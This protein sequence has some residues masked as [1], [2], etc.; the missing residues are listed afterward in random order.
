MAEGT[1]G[2][3]AVII[4]AKIGKLNA[5]LNQAKQKISGFSKASS[6]KMKNFSDSFSRAG[7]GITAFG[8]ITTLVMKKSIDMFAKFQKGLADVST[9]LDQTTLKFMKQYTKGVKDLS[10]EFGEATDSL[11]KGLYDILS[12]S[13]DASKAM[14]VLTVATKAAKA[15]VTTTAVAVDAITTILNSYGMEAEEAMKVSDILFATVKRGKITFEEL[16]QGIGQV[17]SMGAQAG[18]SLEA[19]TAT[20]ATMTRMG[21]KSAEAMT[22]MRGILRGFL[23]PVDDAKIAFDRYMKSIGETN[24]HLDLNTLESEGLI[25][26]LNKLSGANA[27]LLAKMFPNIRGLK[28]ILAAMADLEGVT[29]DLALTTNSAGL[30]MIAFEK[31]TATLDF[32][33]ERLKKG[34]SILMINAITPLTQG[35]TKIATLLADVISKVSEW[36]EKH[37]V[38]TKWIV[39]INIVLGV[40]AVVVGGL[41][42]AL[43][44]LIILIETMT[45]AV[46]ALFWTLV[47]SP[48]VAVTLGLGLLTKAVLNHKEARVKEQNAIADATLALNS[49]LERMIA[50]RKEIEELWDNGERTAEQSRVY[51]LILQAI[52]FYKQELIKTNKELM[53]SGLKN[54]R[55][56][57]EEEEKAAE[58]TRKLETD[59]TDYK[60]SLLDK[61]FQA[62]LDKNVDIEVAIK[63]HQA[64]IKEIM[65][66]SFEE[67][68]ELAEQY[69]Q[70][71]ID[72][73]MS[74]T[75]FTLEEQD[76]LLQELE[77]KYEEYLGAY[78]KV[79]DARKLMEVKELRALLPFYQ[80]FYNGIEGMLT[81]F[82]D[83]WTS[84][85]TINAE[86][87]MGII[88]GLFD[89][90]VDAFIKM[91]IRMAA[92]EIFSWLFPEAKILKGLMGFHTGGIIPGTPGEEVIIKA[93]AGEEVLTQ[94]QST[95]MRGGDN[96]N[97][98][99]NFYM[100]NYI[101]SDM[102]IEKVSHDLAERIKDNEAR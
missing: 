38:L 29:A 63:W 13:I 10:S 89:S 86:K 83:L 1:L 11:S 12:A 68:H 42:I 65:D 8:A 61:E 95:A 64:K 23:K 15:G 75:N 48:I 32:Q 94:Q 46:T 55:I 74:N 69:A 82:W 33:I 17:A 45:I 57:S 79:L 3:L 37:P 80:G 40:F 87:I 18:I 25:Q 100:E 84:G 26:I 60:L 41:L 52:V 51:G 22:A 43:P 90:I 77:P 81:D 67:L 102:D 9:M 73:I 62:L 35:L 96:S 91:T 44:S 21:V 2:E 53:N 50:A 98:T 39:E 58:E 7:I 47:A 24:T 99:F 49:N 36:T 56:I 97:K 30:T 19:M 34:M 78:Q 4:S 85:E 6:S 14:D 28:G 59:E 72:L 54:I 71:D 93:R 101:S 76:R 16:S 70:E 88:Q 5:G 20:I 27:E 92:F 31:T 66:E